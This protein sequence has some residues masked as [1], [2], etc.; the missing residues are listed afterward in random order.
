MTS[1]KRCTFAIFGNKNCMHKNKACI[2]TA[3]VEEEVS[4][5]QPPPVVVPILFDDGGTGSSSRYQPAARAFRA[6]PDVSS[7]GKRDASQTS[8]SSSR[9]SGRMQQ[10]TH[11]L[12]VDLIYS[13]E[14]V[15]VVLQESRNWRI[16]QLHHV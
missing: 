2:R 15:A 16:M 9:Q 10:S 13:F 5:Q 1:R 4:H 7:T 11:W 8:L 12:C 6:S 3:W 14:N